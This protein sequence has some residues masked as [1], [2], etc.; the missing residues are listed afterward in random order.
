M[1]GVILTLN[2]GSSNLKFGLYEMDGA[3]ITGGKL[4][5]SG[6]T[7]PDD[8][9]TQVEK[10]ISGRRPSLV[11]HR[12]VHG[13]PD[14]TGPAMLDK[15]AI[16]KL[17]RLSPLA[18]LH[19]PQ[20]LALVRAMSSRCPEVPQIG[21][22]DTAFHATLPPEAWRYALPRALEN[23]G[24]RRY[25]F[26]GLSY[27]YVA[28]KLREVAPGQACGRIIIAHLGA[29]SSLCAIKDGASIDT[30]MGFTPLDGLAMATR[31]GALDPG[32]VLYLLEQLRMT[33]AEIQDL[34]YRQSGLMGVSGMSGDMRELLKSGSA[35]ARDAVELY[36]YRVAREIGALVSSLGGLDG[37]IFTGGIGENA[38]EIRSRICARLSW[39]R[40][41][42]DEAGNACNG[43]GIGSA[44]CTGVWV[45]PTDEESVIARQAA[46][47][48]SG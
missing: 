26:H 18:P 1:N 15:G 12:I 11:G 4:E 16:A 20:S 3:R 25:G 47:F 29:G 5:T 35:G 23:M 2:A 48:L 44:G 17:E 9:L 37:L 45:I 40:I 30:S 46:S 28:R 38:A 24:I 21:C 31:C 22:F 42:L 33:P 39:L 32:V 36:T 19:Q 13:G 34:L 43:G 8:V 14:F 10:A 6:L 41:S 27:D 7:A